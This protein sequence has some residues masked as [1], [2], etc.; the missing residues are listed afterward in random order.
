MLP[1]ELAHRGALLLGRFATGKTLKALG[2]ASLWLEHGASANIRTLARGKL[3]QRS[4][5]GF[6]AGKDVA[7]AA[8]C[9]KNCCFLILKAHELFR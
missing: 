7:A 3:E 4:E 8:I 1:Q 5:G 6:H 9:K 2:L